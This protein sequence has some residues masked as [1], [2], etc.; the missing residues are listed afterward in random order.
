MT[1]VS[2]GTT[3]FTEISIRANPDFKS[4]GP[5][6]QVDAHLNSALNT[7][8][9]NKENN[10]F[11]A[12]L[13][14][15]LEPGNKINVPYYFDIICLVSLTIDP[16][17]PEEHRPS[18]ATQAAHTVAFPAVRELILNLTARQPWGQFFIGLS[19]LQPSKQT[20]L[21]ISDTSTGTPK[22]TAKPTRKPR[23][24]ITPE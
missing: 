18:L 5:L 4:D 1:P 10:Q 13:R 23:K 7:E 11:A 22:A 21:E 3:F 20:K 2:F 14:V 9:I 15:K 17:V 16:S 6:Q 19:V 8:L 24:K 12:E